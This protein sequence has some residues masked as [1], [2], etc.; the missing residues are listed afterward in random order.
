MKIDKI[1]CD[2]CNGEMDNCECMENQLRF[3]L[4]ETMD[5]GKTYE[6]CGAECLK[7]F[8]NR[9]EFENRFYRWRIISDSISKSEEK[10]RE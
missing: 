8:I 2:N 9:K 10:T 7:E 3:I 5:G 1:F 4:N 6:F